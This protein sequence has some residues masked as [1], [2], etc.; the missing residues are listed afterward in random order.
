MLL[1]TYQVTVPTPSESYAEKLSDET[2]GSISNPANRYPPNITPNVRGNKPP[3]VCKPINNPNAKI[4]SKMETVRLT[5]GCVYISVVDCQGVR[6]VIRRR[7]YPVLK[8][9]GR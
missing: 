7:Y 2:G 1:C 9:K 3:T 4:V 8:T 5:P 6:I